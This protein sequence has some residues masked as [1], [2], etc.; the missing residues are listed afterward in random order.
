MGKRCGRIGKLVPGLFCQ[1]KSEPQKQKHST[2]GQL[3][4]ESPYTVEG[5]LYLMIPVKGK[6][7]SKSHA[8]QKAPA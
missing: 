3:V 2:L 4:L 6:R 8:G 1:G 7:K 5:G